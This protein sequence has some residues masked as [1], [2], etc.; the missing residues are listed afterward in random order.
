MWPSPAALRGRICELQ[1]SSLLWLDR[2]NDSTLHRREKVW[3]EDPLSGSGLAGYAAGSCGPGGRKRHGEDD[4][5]EDA[6]PPGLVGLRLRQSPAR[7][8]LRV[9]SPGWAVA[10]RADGV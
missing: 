7:H 1:P 5:A 10:F 8:A 2:R 4:T 9:P 6:G 3:P